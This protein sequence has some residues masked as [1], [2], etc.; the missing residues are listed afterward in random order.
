V[1]GTILGASADGSYIYFAAN[2][3]QAANSVDHGNGTETA[4]PGDCGTQFATDPGHTCN[5]YLRHQ[6]ATTF[7]ATLSEAED[8]D[9]YSTLSKH[10]SRVSANGRFLVFMSQRPLTGYDNRD[11]A[12]GKPD[13]EVF[14][15]DAIGGPGGHGALTCPSCDSTGARPHGVEYSKIEGGSAGGDRAWPE[16]QWIAANVPGWTPYQGSPSRAFYQSRYLSETGRLF[17]NSSDELSPADANGTEDVYQYEPPG[18]A[19]APAGDTCITTS[20]TYRPGAGGCVDLISSGTSSEESGFLDASE[21]GE[22]VFFLTAAQLSKRDSDTSLDVYDARVGGGEPEAVKAVEC[23]GDACQQPATP[24]AHPTPGTALVDGPGN[25]LQCPK[26][27]VKQ[28]GRC[29][30]KQKAKKHQKHHKNKKKGGAKK[31]K[32]ANSKH[33]GHK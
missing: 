27:K 2:G 17:F 33:G 14:L 11:A 6:G 29:V 30:K 20:P 31:Q 25:V 4:A 13:Q 23:S 24:P 10:V 28:K 15:Y 16:D 8:R 7:I 21:S 1:P 12:S 18:G 9:W 3:V 22:D 26:G 32:R 19:G 5:L